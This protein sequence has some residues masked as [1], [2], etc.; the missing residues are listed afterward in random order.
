MQKIKDKLLNNKKKVLK[1]S[2]NVYFEAVE[3]K[4]KFAI[5]YDPISQ[6]LYLPQIFKKHNAKRK[7]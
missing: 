7:F 5:F 3:K 2:P 1:Y 4:G 6:P